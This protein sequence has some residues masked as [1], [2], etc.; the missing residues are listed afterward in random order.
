M[1]YGGVFSLAQADPCEYI[2]SY[3]AM[4]SFL[5]E[6]SALVLYKYTLQEDNSTIHFGNIAGED[7]QLYAR[8]FVGKVPN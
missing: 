5:T 1:E 2:Y 7:D 8:D 6:S 4:W 3:T